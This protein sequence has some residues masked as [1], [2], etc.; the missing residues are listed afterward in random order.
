[1][2]REL[3]R[4]H[5]DVLD[6][7]DP[8]GDIPDLEAVSEEPASAPQPMAREEVAAPSP[9]RRPREKR[10]RRS[11]TEAPEPREVDAEDEAAPPGGDLRAEAEVRLPP[12][13]SEALVAP[14]GPTPVEPDREAI[15]APRRSPE[16]DVSPSIPPWPDRSLDVLPY[17]DRSAWPGA[18]IAESEPAPV[19]DGPPAPA[20][21]DRDADLEAYSLPAPRA[22]S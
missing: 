16:A 7:P 17:A 9:K 12:E 21:T 19:A 1:M 4:E 2:D 13:P 11:E 6:R 3:P 22:D 14:T 5:D 8:W 20:V 15:D 10:A 18:T